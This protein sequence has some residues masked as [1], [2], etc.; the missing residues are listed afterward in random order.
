MAIPL[1]CEQ[2]RIK[3]N[4]TVED[5]VDVAKLKLPDE[6]ACEVFEELSKDPERLVRFNLSKNVEIPDNCSCEIFG[7]LSKDRDSGV[8]TFTM[9]N[10]R[11][12]MH[13]GGMPDSKIV[14]W[15][16]FDVEREEIDCKMKCN[17][18]VLNGQ[19]SADTDTDVISIIN[20]R[21]ETKGFLERE[22]FIEKPKNITWYRNLDSV[23]EYIK[24]TKKG[25]DIRRALNSLEKG[26]INE[27]VKIIFDKGLQ[28]EEYYRQWYK[29]Y[30]KNMESFK[31]GRVVIK[32]TE[33]PKKFT[34][35]YAVKNGKVIGG[36]LFNEH[37]ESNSI[38]YSAF[39]KEHK[40]L[41]EI[42]YAKIIDYTLSQNK[43]KLFLGIDT[44]FYG[45]H[46]S[47]GVYKSKILFGFTPRGYEAK[48]KEMFLVKRNDKFDDMY[49]FLS[50]D[51]R[52]MDKLKNNIFIK[53]KK[54]IDTE[55]YFAPHGTR[56][57]NV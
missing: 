26:K 46:L 7:R 50:T 11:F 33:Y 25:R 16:G 21:D 44:N 17:I 18:P 14:K 48:G 57:K 30:K 39:E 40:W 27:D 43:K 56:V 52:N 23:D 3:L 36:R 51:G 54:E 45:Y 53:G 35:M 12:R 22:G 42:A 47:P 6:C 24:D 55:D 29:I 32:E 9:I 38:A 19:L 5:R 2:I 34:A 28:N 37:S 8:R 10:D 1:T 49:M 15:H 13:C 31:R 4:G 41:D 20:M